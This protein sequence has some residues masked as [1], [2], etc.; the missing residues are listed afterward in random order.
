MKQLLTGLLTAV[1]LLHSAACG[2]PSA[3]GAGAPGADSPPPAASSAS[4][5]APPQAPPDGSPDTPPG[6]PP[7]DPPGP[8]PEGGPPGPP[9][10]GFG[11]PGKVTQGTA[12]ATL[13]S[14]GEYSGETYASSKDDENALRVDGASVVLRGVTVTKPS[15]SSSS[16]ESGDFYGM[17]A[18]LLATGGAQLTIED[19]KVTSD[20]TNGNG[21]FSYGK[22][23]VVNISNSRITTT[24]D[25]SG[26]IQT[27]GGGTTNASSL[28]V[29]TYG[30]SAAAIRSDRGGGIVIV[31][32]GSY[33]SNGYNSP[34]IYSTADIRVKN[35]ELTA[36][37]SEAMV[38][39]GKNSITLENCTVT[40]N[41]S[42][43]EGSS[44]DE[45][46]HA[47]MIYQSMSGDADVGTSSFSM[48]GGFLLG[49]N[50]DLFHLTNTAAVIR[51]SKVQLINEDGDALLM[52][53][54]GNDA[55]H[56]WGKAGAN[57]ARVEF[58]AD[59]QVLEGS[60]IVDR[61]SSLRMTLAGGSTF[62]GSINI[63]DNAQNGE[64]VSDSA[65]LTIEAGSTWSLTEN[66]T[67]TRLE[68][69]GTI[70]YNG[71]TV[72]LEDGT[73]LQDG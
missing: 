16:T 49:K 23:T 26:G 21:V 44:S 15:G 51:L 64:P 13:D 37:N 73:V 9:P 20:V 50:G 63:V 54:T 69:H 58:T 62:T 43:T 38:I 6:T 65:V 14:D 52:S 70:L 59:Q 30:N 1:L 22:D 56:G 36:N 34:A 57:G 48:T 61:I 25:H 45:N 60:I 11:E 41:M 46:V 31:D 67:L 33:T 53:V 39:E 29:Q 71:F 3:G 12:A 28:T 10:G 55:S 42:D 66:S 2:G 18:A 8:P 24:G 27:T 19:A 32:G 4:P 72:T 68:N 40:G 17:N 47:V 35:A 7:G 5:D